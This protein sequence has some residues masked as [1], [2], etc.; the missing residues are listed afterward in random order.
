MLR[1]FFTLGVRKVQHFFF[2]FNERESDDDT[3]N[4]CHI[5]CFT[6]PNKSCI[7]EVYL[8]ALFLK[9]WA[10]QDSYLL[11]LGNRICAYES[12]FN[13][14][15]FDVFRRFLVPGCYEIQISKTRKVAKDEFHVFFLLFFHQSGSDKRWVAHDVAEF[16]VGHNVVPVH[17]QG[18][19][20]NN[21]GVAG[22][23]QKVKVGVNKLYGF[24]H[25][26]RFGNP[27]RGACHGDGKVVDFDTVKLADGYHNGI[28]G[29]AINNL[30]S[31]QGGDDFV[32]K[33]AKR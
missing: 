18:V 33:S 11:T 23:W 6:V 31:A 15:V 4:M 8:D 19:I 27:K 13:A 7:G 17:A 21:V 14:G 20:F 24:A 1:T 28:D 32:F 16:C 25:H 22:E 29:V 30:G 2:A 5:R 26:L 3:I 9:Q 12:T 10:P